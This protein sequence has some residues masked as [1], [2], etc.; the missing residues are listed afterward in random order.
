MVL[1]PG[2]SRPLLFQLHLTGSTSRDLSLRLRYR[3]E[4]IPT[5]QSTVTFKCR[6]SITHLHAPHK[7]TFRLQSGIV[8]YFMLRAPSKNVTK[9]ADVTRRLPIQLFLHGAGAEADDHHISHMLDPLPDLRAFLL[10]PTGST[11]WSG[12]D[13][14]EWGFADVKAAI[15]SIHDWIK[16]VGWQ[17]PQVDHNKWLVSGHSNG[18]QGTLYAMTHYPDRI[19]GAAAVSGYLSI[20]KY[21]PYHSWTE[22]DSRITQNVQSSLQSFRHELLIDNIKSIPVL[23]QHGSEDDNVPTYHSRRLHQLSSQ[24]SQ[25]QRHRYVELAGKGHWYDGIMTTPPLKAFYQQCLEDEGRKAG[26]PRKY[27]I[28][29]ANPADTGSVG[30]LQ[31]DLLLT[32]DQLGKVEVAHDAFANVVEIHTSNVKR[33]H[34]IESPMFNAQSKVVVDRQAILEFGRVYTSA[35]RG[36]SILWLFYE[37]ET[38]K[39]SDLIFCC[40]PFY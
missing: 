32:P 1:T 24:T 20:Q 27:D 8:S 16:Q 36:E 2:Q 26:L 3:S 23:L 31:V 6:L 30:N 34:F 37:N 13:W 39:V 22:A 7:V 35:E 15:T 29:V 38:W 25:N 4:D 5:G 14:H 19:I 28:L 21:V 40:C 10:Y 11:P 33:F 12:D 9:D 18:G 17:G